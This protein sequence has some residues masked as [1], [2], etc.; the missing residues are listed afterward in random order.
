MP[1]DKAQL[2]RTLTVLQKNLQALQERR[3]SLGP[4][5]PPHLSD[6]IRRAKAEITRIESQLAALAKAGDTTVSRPDTPAGEA[7]PTPTTP[8]AQ[9][10]VILQELDNILETLA[11][12]LDFMPGPARPAAETLLSN[13]RQS[14]QKLAGDSTL[15]PEQI[16]TR[17]SRLE[18]QLKP[19]NQRRIHRR[20][21]AVMYEKLVAEQQTL[22][23]EV[24]LQKVQPRINAEEA[25]IAELESATFTPPRN[26]L[27][28]KVQEVQRIQHAKLLVSHRRDLTFY[29]EMLA[30]QRPYAPVDLLN[31][32]AD[33]EEELAALDKQFQDN[34]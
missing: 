7:A 33:T 24:L 32:I 6:Q 26:A 23:P 19:L 31:S 5:A 25:T 34:H 13:V 9:K 28:A 4:T 1:E 17:A 10:T 30:G 21:L 14:R 2:Q 27:E 3:S 22:S 18:Q 12:E 8:E 20:R 11:I 16:R 15:T 29:R